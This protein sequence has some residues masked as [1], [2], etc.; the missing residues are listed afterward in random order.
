LGAAKPKSDIEI[1]CEYLAGELLKVQ[2]ENAALKTR[3]QELELKLAQAT[4][5]PVES[6]SPTSASSKI[7]KSLGHAKLVDSVVNGA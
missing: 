4:G 7:A 2:D 6:M 5:Q 1:R 3:I